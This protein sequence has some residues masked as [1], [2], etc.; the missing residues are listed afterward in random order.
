MS[1]WNHLRSLLFIPAGKLG[2]WDKAIDSGADAIC[3]D[4][5][6][7]VP[8]NK[9]DSARFEVMSF[10]NTNT[11]N[12]RVK[13]LIRIN[14]SEFNS[15][16]ADIEMLMSLKKL[17]DALMI[18]KLNK[19][20]SL[21]SLGHK[22]NSNGTSIPFIPLIETAGAL[23]NARNILSHDRVTGAV[24]GGH[25]LAMQLGCSKDWDVLSAYRSEFIKASGGQNLSL[26]DMPWFGLNDE[27]GLK[28]ETENAK[29]Y[30]FTAK[31]AI[32]PAQVQVINTVF[33][34]TDS[35]I[36]EANEVIQ[37]F[38]NSAGHAVAWKGK[39]LEPPVINQAKRVIERASNLSHK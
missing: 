29:R 18:P 7:S 12:N 28:K 30:G 11:S 9:K 17:P 13:I 15:G 6:D 34:P 2:K 8:P 4:L 21:I 5:E 3:I 37:A 38:E 32:H 35:E 14:S 26:I 16:L 33:T 25:D 39:V 10:L 36:E 31:A 22:L 1:E 19:V 20:D 27:S 24:F 23:Y